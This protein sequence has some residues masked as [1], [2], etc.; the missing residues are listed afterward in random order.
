VI[1]DVGERSSIRQHGKETH[2][3]GGCSAGQTKLVLA[4]TFDCKEG[5]AYAA[6]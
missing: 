4:D 1:P 2:L 5:R 6:R 3:V